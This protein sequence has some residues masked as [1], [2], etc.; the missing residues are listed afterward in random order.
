VNPLDAGRRDIVERASDVRLEFL[1]PIRQ[2]RQPT[3]PPRS[4]RAMRE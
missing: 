4:L 1:E 3:F 2:R